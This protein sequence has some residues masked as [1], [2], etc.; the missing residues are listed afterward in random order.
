MKV[1]YLTKNLSHDWQLSQNVSWPI[2]RP[3]PRHL[4]KIVMRLRLLSP[5]HGLDASDIGVPTTNHNI[6]STPAYGRTYRLKSPFVFYFLLDGPQTH[7][8]LYTTHGMVGIGLPPAR[9][10]QT[11]S[12]VLVGLQPCSH[13][14]SYVS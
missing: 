5:Q 10:L 2:F 6:L 11:S 3:A 4:G 1:R 13:H 9:L 7:V 8:W 14:S 12:V